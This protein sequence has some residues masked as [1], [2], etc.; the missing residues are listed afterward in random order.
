MDTRYLF[1]DGGCLRATL[2]NISERYFGGNPIKIDYDRLRMGHAKAFYYDAIPAIKFGESDEDYLAR[3]KE[4]RDLHNHIASLDA[5]HVYEGDSRVRRKQVQQK[6]VDVMIAVD[7]LT[8]TFRRNMQR[9]TFIASDLDFKPLL[10]AL[11]REGMFTHLMYP[12]EDTNSNLVNAADSRTPLH[13]AEII[14]YLVEDN[15]YFNDIPRATLANKLNFSIDNMLVMDRNSTVGAVFYYKNSN[16]HCLVFQDI[17]NINL[18][19]QISGANINCMAN[20]CADV[21]GFNLP[22]SYKDIMV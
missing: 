17:R 21:Y 19:V 9:A 1:I 13:I 16:E 10:D 11:V 20:Y 14:Q 18:Y 4:R 3:T 5:Y 12:P 7:M 22:D 2:K 15:V 8:H 6:E